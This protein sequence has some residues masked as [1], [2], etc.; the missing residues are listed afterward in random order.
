[1][2]QK[3]IVQKLTETTAQY[4]TICFFRFIVLIIGLENHYMFFFMAGP[5]FY[6]VSTMSNAE[7]LQFK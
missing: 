6:W 7:F 3:E 1:M 2:R 4:E 5:I